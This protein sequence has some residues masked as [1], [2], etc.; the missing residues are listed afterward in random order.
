MRKFQAESL[1]DVFHKVSTIQNM[2]RNKENH[3]FSRKFSLKVS[4]TIKTT[5]V[6]FS[7]RKQ[8]LENFKT[9]YIYIQS[10]VKDL[11]KNHITIYINEFIN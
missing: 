9:L 7:K 4:I 5:S 11:F 8:N 1:E 10:K 3:Q 2:S 6:S